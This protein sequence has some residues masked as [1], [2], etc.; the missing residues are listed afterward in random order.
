MK[1]LFLIRH[2][3]SSWSYPSLPDIDRP[4]NERGYRDAHAMSEYLARQKSLPDIIISSPA[5]RAVSTA[6]IFSRTLK[7]DEGGISLL[8]SLYE[9]TT[10]EYLRAVRAQD[11]QYSNLFLVAHNPTI[12]EFFSLLTSNR[13]EDLSTCAIA[14]AEFEIDEWEKADFGLAVNR[15]VLRPAMLSSV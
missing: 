7:F 2:A 14:I 15:G 6:L 8:P 9:S 3:K 11:K 5:I 4:L 13:E 10:G 12:S 1:K